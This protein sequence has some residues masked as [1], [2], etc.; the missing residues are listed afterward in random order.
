[1]KEKKKPN[2]G[3]AVFGLS[4]LTLLLIVILAAC[5]PAA[6]EVVNNQPE[7]PVVVDEPE[8]EPTDAPAPTPLPDQ[9]MQLASWESGAHNTY[10]LY[11]G[12]N[13]WCAR[14]HSPQN[15]DP[16]A[17]PGTPPNCFSCKFPM[18]EEVRISDGNDLILEED[19]VGINCATCHEVDENGIAA[20]GIAWL[21]PITM[22]YQDVHTSTELC[23]K[24]HVTTVG[25]SFGSAVEHKITLGGS[26]HLNYGGFLGDTPPPQYCADCH[27][28]HT[29]EPMTCDT[30]HDV[31]NL[32]THIMGYNFHLKKVS[33]MACHDAEGFDVG[34]HPSDEAALWTTQ[35][36]EMGRGGPS[37]SAVISHSPTYEVLCNKCHFAENPWGLTELTEDG[38]IPEPEAA[39]EG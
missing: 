16:E 17:V 30:C 26:A 10:D 11:H 21:N 13:T 22:E 9:S 34:P 18:D 29:L 39:P 35:V 25:N 28:P 36:T 8:P 14:C 37:T 15:W 20:E 2:L 3:N 32:D 1:M 6:P 5:Q 23:E 31:A 12:P 24:C 38:E 4:L 7:E 27:D 33:C 19:W